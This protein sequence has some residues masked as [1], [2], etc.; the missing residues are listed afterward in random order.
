MGRLPATYAGMPIMF[1]CP[2]VMHTSLIAGASTH[3]LSFQTGPVTHASDKPFEVHRMIPRVSGLDVSSVFVGT[4]PDEDIMSALISITIRDFGKNR[5][6]T[7]GLTL[8]ANFV[9]GSA[10]RTWEWADPYYMKQ[11]DGFEIRGQTQPFPVGF[12]PVLLKVDIAFE[13]FEIVLAPP[14][15]RR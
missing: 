4:Q 11:G 14:T 15:D 10:E 6:L 1:R 7:K 8:L 12:A 2:A 5:A 13:G 9:R 3:G